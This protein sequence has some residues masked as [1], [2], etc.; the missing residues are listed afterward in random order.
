MEEIDFRETCLIDTMD[1][2]QILGELIDKITI[3][4]FSQFKNSF[5]KDL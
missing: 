4:T 5:I 1:N 3:M 2:L